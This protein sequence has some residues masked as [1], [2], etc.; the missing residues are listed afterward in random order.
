MAPGFDGQKP[1]ALRI[2][3]VVQ[4]ALIAR[5]E[6]ERA[7]VSTQVATLQSQ[8][9]VLESEFSADYKLIQGLQ[10]AARTSYIEPVVVAVW[11][12][13]SDPT[14]SSPGS[15]QGVTTNLPIY[16]GSNAA[17]GYAA[18]QAMVDDL[19]HESATELRPWQI[20]R[21]HV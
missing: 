3:R 1:L 9:R 21:A 16:S 14:C 4:D 11:L 18:I 10:K 12:N 20:G 6:S 15:G 2:F 19:L 13:S 5:T 7:A 17:D 8:I